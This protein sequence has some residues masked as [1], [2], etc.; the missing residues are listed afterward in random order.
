MK[1]H[2]ILQEDGFRLEFHSIRQPGDPDEY[3]RAAGERVG[4]TGYVLQ[5]III[6]PPHRLTQAKH[7]SVK[8]FAP[9]R[10]NDPLI[11]VGSADLA[12]QCASVIAK[13][14]QEKSRI[15]IRESAIKV[16]S[17]GISFLYSAPI[18]APQEDG[19]SFVSGFNQIT[20]VLQHFSMREPSIARTWLYMNNVL[21]D[22]E[23]LNMA[24]ERYFAKWYGPENHFMPAS[25]GIQSQTL[26]GAAL[27]IQFCAFAGDHIAVKQ[28]SSPLQNEPTAYGKLFSRAVAVSFPRCE[29]LFISGTAAID[30]S[31]CSVH[32]GNFE[33]QMAFTLD[34]ISAILHQ[35]NGSFSDVAQAI[36]YLKRK[37][38]LELGLSILEERGFPC[39][40]S[41]FQPGV[42]V[43]RQDLL[44]EMEVTAVMARSS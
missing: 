43:C 22:Y 27:A 11:L 37:E 26:G 31:G 38:D 25:T 10:C 9:H 19:C 6:V 23:S 41:L 29:L 32:T 28:V 3:R 4:E 33:K 12:V 20:E 44:C 34:V 8:T 1:P 39:D 16:S 21:R 5:E 2:V 7:Y 18:W 42:D 13:P 40:R 14:N 17:D 15:E 30:K 35:E 36:V 24:R